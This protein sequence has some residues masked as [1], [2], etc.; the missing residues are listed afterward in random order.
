[1][2]AEL[3][4]EQVE[5]VL[6]EHQGTATMFCRGCPGLIPD[7]AGD[8]GWDE[9]AWI[10]RHQADKIAA[11]ADGVADR[12]L[13]ELVERVEYAGTRLAKVLADP[14]VRHFGSDP[15]FL[16]VHDAQNALA[17]VRALAAALG[18]TSE[19]GR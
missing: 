16:A 12:D 1:M 2:S 8:L 13:A 14:R 5:T 11:L 3:S 15:V 6:A 10:R 9:E 17:R 18:A 7:D 19:T 4:A